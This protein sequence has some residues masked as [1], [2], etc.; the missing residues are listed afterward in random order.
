MPA[1]ERTI[2]AKPPRIAVISPAKS[3]QIPAHKEANKTIKPRT[4]KIIIPVLAA[5]L[6]VKSVLSLAL[7]KI[8]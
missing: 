7:P 3:K 1:I 2:R 8:D 4:A 6:L 5:V